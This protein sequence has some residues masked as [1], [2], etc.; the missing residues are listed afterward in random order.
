LLPDNPRTARRARRFVRESWVLQLIDPAMPAALNRQELR[1]GAAVAGRILV[2]RWTGSA[3]DS[4]GGILDL[5]ARELAAEGFD[6]VMFVAGD[7]DWPNR[8]AALL[9]QG[10][11]T[12]ALTMSGIGAD[13]VVDGGRPIWEAAKIPLFNW[14]CDHAC[15]FPSRHAMRSRFLLHGYIFVEHARY[16]IRYLNPNGMAFA[17]HI[18]IPPRGTF[19]GAPLPLAARNGRIL[20]TKSGQDTNAIEAR[21][22][23]NPPMLQHILFAAAEE[24][25]HCGTADF[26]PTLQRI[27]ETQGLVLDGNNMLTLTLIRELDAYIRYRRGNRVIE[28]LLGHPVDVFGSG[29]D[30]VA[31]PGGRAASF[32]GVGNWQA[33]MRHLPQYLGRLSVDP[34]IGESFHDRVF[35]ALAAGVPPVTEA[36]A[37]IRAQA[38]ALEPYTFDATREQIGQAVDAVLSDP[39]DA[40]A[41]TEA[42]WQAMLPAFSMRRSA[43]QIV[44]CVALSGLN[45]RCAI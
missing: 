43:Q 32:H 17:I 6:V 5:T 30:H 40:L 19:P 21:W 20:F 45:A 42:T 44:Q 12:F 36:N 41:R 29:W 2:L 4:L 18:G 3:Y 14:N 34:L 31:W 27:G 23:S 28:A 9:S 39:A 16:N 1:H 26:V 15:Y 10:G 33:T 13:F 35:F 38:P 37:F 8:L 24:L 11:F 22:R 25:L 7:K